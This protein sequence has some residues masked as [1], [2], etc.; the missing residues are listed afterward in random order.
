MDAND[1]MVDLHNTMKP[2]QEGF[3]SYSR[4]P[5]EGRS[6][7]DILEELKRYARREEPKWK[8]GMVSGAVYHGDQDY[9]DFQN[10]AYGIHS[11]NNPLHFDVWPS[12]FK[13]EAEIVSMTA[14]MLGAGQ[15]DDPITGTISSGG[16]ESILLAMK[17]YREWAREHKGT[18]APEVI[19]PTT[20]H[21]AFDKA[22]QYFCIK[23]HR[24]PVLADSRADIAAMAALINENT[25]ALVG[26]APHFP[27]GIVDPIDELSELAR[28]HGIGFHTDACLG[29]FILPWAEKLGYPVPPFDFRLPGVTSISVDTH[30]YGYAAKGTSVVL[31][32][33]TALRHYQYFTATEWP[34]GLYLSPTLAG[35][36]SGGLSAACWAALVSMGERGYLEAAQKILETAD[37]IKAGICE[38]PELRVLGNPLFVIA[39]TADNLDIYAVADLMTKK[40]WS[41]NSLQKPP[42]VHISVTIRHTQ[43]GVA[44]KFLTDL[45]ETVAYL[46]AHP[47]VQGNMTPVYGLAGT[48]EYSG[49]VREVLKGVL[50]MAYTV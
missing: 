22:A 38:I 25:I 39:I 4:L 44:D 11:Q 50:D 29:G 24:V 18:T 36:R 21:V 49:A 7:E 42:A 10:Q 15:T 35:S 46:K 6:R 12:T 19:A 41:L 13:F 17:T 2:Y 27:H 16:T 43:P 9:I 32:R 26:S 3:S 30:K 40:G 31:Y 20:A 34:G 45:R 5:A 33:G 8:Q 28:S 47:E 37:A 48:I 23:L 1:F 14:H